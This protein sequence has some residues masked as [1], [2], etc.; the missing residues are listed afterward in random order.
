MEAHVSAVSTQATS[1]GPDQHGSGRG[2]RAEHR[3]LPRAGVRG[4][5]QP[6]PIRPRRD[7]EAP[8]SPRL[9]STGRASCSRVKTRSGPS[10]VTRSRSG[11]RRPSSGCP[12]PRS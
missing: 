4:V 1:V 10:A 2:D 6:H 12:S 8:G 5:D 7:V 3:Q 11:M 9:S